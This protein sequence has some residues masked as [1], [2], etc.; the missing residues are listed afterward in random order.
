VVSTPTGPIAPIATS[1]ASPLEGVVLDGKYRILGEIGSGGMGSV[2][3]AEL[4]GLRR[5]VAIKIA[6]NADA[7]L[8]REAQ[9]VAT[10]HHPNICTAFDVG[11][12]P[13]GGPYVVLERLYGE[14]LAARIRRGPLALREAVEI[15]TQ[16]LSG[17]QAAH[18]AGIVH[19]DIKPENIFLV[20]RPGLAPSVK[21]LDFGF[22]RDFSGNRDM[23]T[24]TKPGYIC[25]T[26]QYMAP[27][28][29]VAGTVD[30]RAD[31]FAVGTILFQALTCRA[32]FEG[33][34][35]QEIRRNILCSFPERLTRLR[36]DVPRELDEILWR[37]LGKH[38]AQRYR[39]AVVFQHA[40][41]RALD[42]EEP[43]DMRD[44]IDHPRARL[45][46]LGSSSSNPSSDSTTVP[47]LVSRESSV[48]PV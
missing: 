1:A 18:G 29:L 40:L 42:L 11:R 45:P 37:A 20:S 26:P 13:W 5:R 27:E 41:I 43:S 21:I 6:K 36:K 8:H 4:I 7:R 12:T 46:S 48:S 32:P 47:V 19:R 22:A 28:Q 25:G 35:P 39:N 14:T 44:T 9:L 30:H 31:L 33:R 34:T 3:E 23:T 38:P 10:L 15:V 2:Y 24:I 16:I 17:L